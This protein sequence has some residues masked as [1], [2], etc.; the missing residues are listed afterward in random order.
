MILLRTHVPHTSCTG[1][2]GARLVCSLEGAGGSAGGK[3]AYILEESHSALHH[4]SDRAVDW[5][6]GQ[7]GCWLTCLVHRMITGMTTTGHAQADRSLECLREELLEQGLLVETPEVHFRD[8]LAAHSYAQRGQKVGDIDAEPSLLAI[9]NRLIEL[10]VLPL[11]SA[12]V[13]ERCKT[14][15]LG[16]PLTLKQNL[17]LQ[18]LTGLPDDHLL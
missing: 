7:S 17:S 11:V 16:P 2:L 8:F 9:R 4:G 6:E 18:H 5:G 13:R 1:P 3:Q 10:C 14:L 12:L 15:L